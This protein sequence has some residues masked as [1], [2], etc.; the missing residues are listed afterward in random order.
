MIAM[1][2]VA[3]EAGEP[4]ALA[5]ELDVRDVERVVFHFERAVAA[6]AIAGLHRYARAGVFAMAAL[7]AIWRQRFAHFR[8][9]RLRETKGGMA[10]ERALVTSEAIVVANASEPEI[11]RRFP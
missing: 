11:G 9:T 3:A 6:R 10:I 5:H 7:T 8:K 2:V 1:E 4:A